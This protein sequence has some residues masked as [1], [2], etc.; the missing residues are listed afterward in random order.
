VVLHADTSFLPSSL[1]SNPLQGVKEKVMEMAGDM[2]C[3]QQLREQEAQEKALLRQ[4]K[5]L[6]LQENA[7]SAQERSRL[8]QE[9]AELRPAM[10][11]SCKP[12]K[13]NCHCCMPATIC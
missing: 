6:L 10:Q 7:N 12:C 3:L 2:V 9:N 11:V 1:P 4:E 5:A 8:L 13:D